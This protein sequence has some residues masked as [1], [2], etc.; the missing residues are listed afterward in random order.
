MEKVSLRAKS[1]QA[2]IIGTV[3]SISGAFVVTLYKGPPI[4]LKPSVS[5][6]QPTLLNSQ[7]SSWII[8]G[9][10]LTAEYTLIPLFN[11]VQVLYHSDVES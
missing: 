10:L 3:V 1:S 11:I 6:P 2:K 8:G 7:N 4:I 9:M 5:L